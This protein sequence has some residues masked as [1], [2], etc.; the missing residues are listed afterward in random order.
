ME[1]I[2]GVKLSPAGY[3]GAFSFKD[4]PGDEQ[5]RHKGAKTPRTVGKWKLENENCKMEI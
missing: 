2:A 1:R 4:E 3:G 5:Q